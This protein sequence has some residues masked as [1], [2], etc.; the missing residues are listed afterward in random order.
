MAETKS[1]QRDAYPLPAYNFRVTIGGEAMSFSEVSGVT[2]D[3]ETVTYKHGL[4]FSEGE[5][6]K[7]YR[8][9]KFVPIRLKKGTVKGNY[10]YEWLK[11]KDKRRLDI[12]LCDEEGKAVVNWVVGKAV[13]VKLEAPTFDANTNEVAIETLEVMAANISVEHVT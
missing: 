3:Y 4:S 8:Y 9:N 6:L 10:L 13:P 1:H 11:S 7:K 12:S 2:I 5:V